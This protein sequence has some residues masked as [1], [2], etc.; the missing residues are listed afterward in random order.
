MR[1]DASLPPPDV[2]R[3]SHLKLG[4]TVVGIILFGYG[5]RADLSSFRWIG[6]GFLAVAVVLRFW[7]PRNSSPPSDA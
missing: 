4:L 7:K 2:T 5:V 6:I 1:S 3:L